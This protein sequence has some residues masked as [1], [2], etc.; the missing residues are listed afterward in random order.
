MKCWKCT[1]TDKKITN[2]F[3]SDVENFIR[4]KRNL[5]IRC[6]TY[7]WDK[8]KVHDFLGLVSISF[9]DH[10][11]LQQATGKW[12]ELWL[13]LQKRTSK[14]KV[15]GEIHLGIRCQIRNQGASVEAPANMELAPAA[16]EA[17]HAEEAN[18]DGRQV[19]DMQQEVQEKEEERVD[20]LHS[21][22]ESENLVDGIQMGQNIMFSINPY[23]QFGKPIACKEGDVWKADALYQDGT[24]C[25]VNM[26]SKSDGSWQ[27]QF[28]PTK[29][30][31]LMLN[32]SLN[33]KALK[34]C[35]FPMTISDTVEPM[36]C[37]AFGE[38]IDPMQI[39]TTDTPIEF[40]V[41]TC[42]AEGIP[43]KIGGNFVYVEVTPELSVA[44]TVYD[45]EDGMNKFLM[46]AYIFYRYL[47][48]F[49][50]SRIANTTLL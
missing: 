12:V 35:P 21:I 37:F 49:L 9:K 23:S 40:N 7:D 32:I 26:V 8:H 13:P 17:Q 43:M 41:Q 28:K 46:L 48:H 38:A 29:P 36:K 30:G 1:L 15:T 20:A 3:F 33:G 50:Y 45:N 42:D 19:E 24:T 39:F 44:P 47:Y 10:P 16:A 22:I 11:D 4:T 14:D 27:C 18:K 34:M 31:K 2:I 6:E 5:S 25:T